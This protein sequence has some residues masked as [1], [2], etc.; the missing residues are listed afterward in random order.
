MGRGNDNYFLRVWLTQFQS[1][2]GTNSSEDNLSGNINED[3]DKKTQASEYD[4]VLNQDIQEDE[5]WAAIK[6]QKNLKNQQQ[7]KNGKSPGPDFVLGELF[8]TSQETVV[9]LLTSY[10]NHLFKNSSLFPE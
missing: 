1:V 6:N 8:K 10:L 2:F 5:V 3:D 4:T 7:L 9:P